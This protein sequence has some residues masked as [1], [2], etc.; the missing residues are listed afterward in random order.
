MENILACPVLA[1]PEDISYTTPKKIVF[2]TN[3]KISFKRRELK[4]LI[5]IAQ[6]HN[7]SIQILHIKESRKL[8]EAQQGNK[9]F[10]ETLFKDVDHSFHEMEGMSVH[11]GINAFIDLR[12]CDMVAFVNPNH[13]FFRSLFS[14]LLVEELGYH[15]KVPVLVLKDR[16]LKPKKM[17]NKP[18]V[19]DREIEKLHWH[20]QRWKADLQFTEHEINFM[21]QL[22]NADIYEQNIPDMFERIQQ[23]LQQLKNH[24]IRTEKLKQLVGNHENLLG[25]VMKSDI[26]TIISDF[27]FKHANVESEVEESKNDFQHFKSEIFNFIGGT[28]KKNAAHLK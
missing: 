2:P 13:S 23:Y 4:Y 18:S 11:T 9:A 7:S 24:K 17:Q 26:D 20:I 21:E 12:K 5:D 6:L 25:T 10:L 14:T 15:S 22:L 28:L 27:D 16:N 8:N 3:Y 19:L 1:I